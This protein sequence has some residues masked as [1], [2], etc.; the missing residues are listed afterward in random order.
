MN[1]EIVSP[2][3]CH[4]GGETHLHCADDKLVH[5]CVCSKEVYTHARCIDD[6]EYYYNFDD[7]DDNREVDGTRLISVGSRTE[8]LGVC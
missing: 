6:H 4:G 5:Q 1:N 2:A 7:C 8:L 3:R